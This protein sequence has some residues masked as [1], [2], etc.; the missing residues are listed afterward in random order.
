MLLNKQKRGRPRLH[1]QKVDKGTKELQE[2]RK[3]L[4][5]KNQGPDSFLAESLLGLFYAHEVISRPL[6]EAGCFFGELGYRYEPCLGHTFRSRTSALISNK[7]KGQSSISDEQDEKYTT[8]WRKALHAL[9]RS[10]P[11]STKVVLKVVFYAQDLHT[12][13]FPKLFLQEIEALNEGLACLEAYFKGGLKDRKGRL[14][15]SV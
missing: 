1:R 9:E 4:L 6:Y 15:G 5:R 2:K 8:A 3:R 10:G 12:N 14:C 7:G 13:T 11:R